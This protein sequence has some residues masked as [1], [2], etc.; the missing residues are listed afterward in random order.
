MTTTILALIELGAILLLL[1]ILG[2]FAARIGMSPVPLYLLGGLG[3]GYG[4]IVFGR[5]LNPMTSDSEGIPFQD[6]GEFTHLASEI[7]VVL[8]LLMLGL[9]YSR[10][11][12]TATGVWGAE[13]RT[14]S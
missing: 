11:L 13:W 3:I 6:I 1:G 5:D 9:E 8:L 7:G 4:G 10:E 14:W 2:R 12:V